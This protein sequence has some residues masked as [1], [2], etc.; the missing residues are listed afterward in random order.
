MNDPT[1]TV[2]NALEYYDTN[3]EKY[4]NI[5]KNIRYIKF[6]FGEDDLTYNIINMYDKNKNKIFSSRYELIGTYNNE[7][8]LWVWSWSRPTMKRNNTFTTKKLVNYG[9][10]LDPKYSFLKSELITS[11]F[12]ITNPI[13]IDIHISLASY[14]SKNPVIFKYSIGKKNI[15]STEFDEFIDITLTD[16]T[17]YSETNYFFILDYNKL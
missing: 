6:E 7:Y 1:K 12:R 3:I 9:I 8:N 14:L 11:R 10:D 13:Q 16:E 2:T 17:E 5:F 4:K 15:E